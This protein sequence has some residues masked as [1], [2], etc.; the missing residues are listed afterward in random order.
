MVFQK[1][2]F[3]GHKRKMLLILFSILLYVHEIMTGVTK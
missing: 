3:T 2:H 1:E